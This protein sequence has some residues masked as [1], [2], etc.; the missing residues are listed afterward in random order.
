MNFSC[1]LG[2]RWHRFSWPAYTHSRARY[3]LLFP[4]P[5]SLPLPRAGS[6]NKREIFKTTMSAACVSVGWEDGSQRTHLP[7]GKR[8]CISINLHTTEDFV[9]DC[10][11]DLSVELLWGRQALDLLRKGLMPPALKL[12]CSPYPFH[13]NT[14]VHCLFHSTVLFSPSLTKRLFI[15]RSGN[16]GSALKEDQCSLSSG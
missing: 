3:I 16:A 4:L 14:S 11:G 2:V 12:S 5:L 15:C 8:D 1:H 6:K 13:F 9:R 7:V 10:F